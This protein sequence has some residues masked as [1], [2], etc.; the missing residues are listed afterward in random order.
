VEESSKPKEPQQSVPE[1]L[2]DL[3][4]PDSEK[5]HRIALEFL[6]QIRRNM[7]TP[8]PFTANDG[9]EFCKRNSFSFNTYQKVRARMVSKG[10]VEKHDGDEAFMISL[11]FVHNLEKEIV[12]FLQFRQK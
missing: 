10:L 7:G 2:L 1:R 8:H 9:R 6:L 4:F 5:E 11:S 12:D 3:I